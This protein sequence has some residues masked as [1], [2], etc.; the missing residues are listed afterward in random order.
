M[1]ENF[2]VLP[3]DWIG[4]FCVEMNSY[5]LY[6]GGQRNRWHI[7]RDGPTTARIGAIESIESK[8]YIFLHYMEVKSPIDMVHKNLGASV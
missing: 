8:E 3:T 2:R 7:G 5:V 1:K 4:T 6:P